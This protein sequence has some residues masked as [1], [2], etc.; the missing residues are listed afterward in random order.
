MTEPTQHKTDGPVTIFECNVTEKEWKQYCQQYDAVVLQ[1]S[2]HPCMPCQTMYPRFHKCAGTYGQKCDRLGFAKIVRG[3]KEPSSFLETL[4]ETYHVTGYPTLILV[5][6]D[7]SYAK[8]FDDDK[9]GVDS[10]LTLEEWVEKV[11]SK[12]IAPEKQNGSETNRTKSGRAG[13][14]GHTKGH[15]KRSSGRRCKDSKARA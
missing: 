9:N 8:H 5:K 4:S 12:I 10:D 15:P 11:T 7:T 14:K 2:L 3:C 13:G 6:P 1:F